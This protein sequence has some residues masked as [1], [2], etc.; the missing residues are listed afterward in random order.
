LVLALSMIGL[1]VTA[2]PSVADAV[3]VVAGRSAMVAATTVGVVTSYTDRSILG[4]YWIAAGPD[5]ALWFTNEGASPGAGSI[6]RISTSGAVSN[7]TDLSISQPL[8]ITTGPDGSLWFTNSFGPGSIGR[9]STAGVVTSYTDPSISAPNRITT[10]PDGALWFTNS[11]GGAAGSIGRISTAGAVSNY[12]DPSISAPGGIT[13][14]PDGALWFTNFNGNSIGRSTTAGVVTSYTDPSISAPLDI[15]VGPDGAL[16]FTNSNGAGG[17][18]GRITTAGV[19]TNYTVPGNDVS[20]GITA[21]PDGALW[22]TGLTSIGRITTA[23]VVTNYTDPSISDPI[24]ISA[25]PDGALWFANFG[26]DSIGRITTGTGGGSGGP[27]C[28]GGSGGPFGVTAS[29]PTLSDN[30]F[31]PS[32]V[33]ATFTDQN[34]HDPSTYQA[35]IDWHDGNGPQPAA[36]VP[37]QGLCQI[38]GDHQ[39]PDAGHYPL[40]IQVS[41]STQTYTA[42]AVVMVYPQLANPA[43]PQ[44][45][46][47]T[48]KDGPQCTATVVSGT[49]GSGVAS[50]KKQQKNWSPNGDVIIT[51]RHCLWGFNPPYYF[52]PGHQ[53]VSPRFSQDFF[54]TGGG[55]IPPTVSP[56]P[57]PSNGGIGSPYAGLPVGPSPYGVWGTDMAPIY[58][59][60][61]TSGDDVA[62]L[63]MDKRVIPPTAPGQGLTLEQAVG[64]G[65]PLK[66]QANGP[67]AGFFNIYGYDIYW[68]DRAYLP[69]GSTTPTPTPDQIGCNN[70]QGCDSRYPVYALG[71]H[72][73][74]APYGG[75]KIDAPTNPPG[76]TAG[77]RDVARACNL[78]GYASGSPFLDPNGNIIDAVNSGN[79]LNPPSSGISNL[80]GSEPDADVSGPLDLRNFHCAEYGKEC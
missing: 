19:V 76:E 46:V 17:S 16:W 60:N 43:L 1:Y 42:S 70:N 79:Y 44:V 58:D 48:S 8:G 66:F 71:Q 64:G 67:S 47:L 49:Q 18:I 78:D 23:G 38:V 15:T 31:Y 10:G 45:G 56:D 2:V 33:V 77:P 7:Y 21:G 61:A 25:G 73:C 3:P 50:Q 75:I 11:N 32:L 36:V 39:Y 65:L 68:A 29:P 57:N 59:H 63:V 52:A 41:Y 4:P 30:Q 80:A 54:P 9:I 27:T 22:F 40:T 51:A 62:F 28:K 53:G 6:G 55:G 12:T 37:Q 69:P 26:G 34:D 35:T 72:Q 20:G 24:A 13:A 74:S 5:G 14:G